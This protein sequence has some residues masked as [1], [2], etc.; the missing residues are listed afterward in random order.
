MSE[1]AG[2][3]YDYVG[4]LAVLFLVAANGF[5]VAAEFALVSVRRSRVTELAAAG[6]MNASALQRAVDNLDANLA[7]TQLGITISSLALGWVGEPA[8]AHLIEPL[9][10]WLPG[11]WA[12]TGAHTVA[13]VIAFVIITALHIVLGELAPKSLALQRSE[14]TSLAV[15]RPLGLFLVLFKPAIFTL[16]GM[17][18]FVLRAVGLRAGT[19]ESSFH[20]PQELKLLV[21]ESHEAGLLNQVQQQLVERVF[22]IGERPISDIMTPRLDIEWFDADDSE[23]EILKTIRECTHEQLLVARGSIDEPIGMVLKKD[24]LDQVLDG[25]KVRPMAVIKQPLVLHEGTSVVR[26]IDSF[27]ASPVRLAIIIDEYGS[28]EGIVTQTDLLEAIAGDLPGADEE[29]DIII[30]EDGSLLIDAMMPAFDAFERLGLR[31]R[32]DADFHTLAGFALHQLQHIPE[33]G[34]T[35]LFEDWRFEVI[36]MDGMRIDKILA[37]RIP[38]DGAES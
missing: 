31:E 21:A 3:L 1:S 27:K 32:P 4:I 22:N 36:D 24:L 8:L 17:G 19:G 9:L 25:G 12:R 23:A 14:A 15:V 20:S 34:E 26:V 10:A 35:F 18:N 28:L 13:I 37:M 38:A 5:F 33:T 7:A 30:R 2:G 16:N 11:E 6:R 29:P